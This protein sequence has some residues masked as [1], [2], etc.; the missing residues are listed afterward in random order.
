MAKTKCAA[1]SPATS[2][3]TNGDK[4]MNEGEVKEGSA[5]VDEPILYYFHECLFLV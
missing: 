4:D 3:T 5:V 1:V 2:V